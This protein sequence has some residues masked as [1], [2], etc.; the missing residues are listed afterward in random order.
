MKLD[1]A[2]ERLILKSLD[3]LNKKITNLENELNKVK[4][5]VSKL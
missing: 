5:K 1:P 4:K 3:P 2:I